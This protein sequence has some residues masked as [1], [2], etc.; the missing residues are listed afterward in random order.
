MVSPKAKVRF[1]A[2]SS[3]KVRNTV[4]FLCDNY[5]TCNLS[6]INKGGDCDV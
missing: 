4:N 3:F 1:Y 5:H 2:Y 6:R